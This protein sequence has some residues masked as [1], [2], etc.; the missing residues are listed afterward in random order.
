MLSRSLFQAL[1][2]VLFTPVFCSELQV[3]PVVAQE[4][5][6][7]AL[8]VKVD[9]IVITFH[10]ADSHGLPVN[11][12]RADELTVFDDD[13]PAGKILSLDLLKDAPI[14]AGI[15]MDTSASMRRD[16]AGN[17]AVSYEYA[18]ALLRSGTDQAFVMGFG[19][20]ARVD[21]SWTNSPAAL[22][23]GIQRIATGSE[24]RLAGTA[25]FDNIA[26]ACRTQFA[27][28][29]HA[30]SGNFILL[31]T[32]GEDNAGFQSIKDAVDACQHANTAIYAF[33]SD[34]GA[35]STGPATLAQLTHET[36]GR[37][38]RSSESPT[39][40]SED[41]RVIEAEMRNQYRLVYR[42]RTLKHDGAFHHIALL[43][44]GRVA[45]VDVRSGYYAPTH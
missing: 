3:P 13:K 26:H 28:I 38:F 35:A 43:P 23:Q 20:L 42:P 44:P 21:P 6:T 14:H 30:T 15:L 7:F 18:K 39:E 2:I 1:S 24:S 8:R 25:L 45:T 41:L 27:P 31:F 5:P 32:D 33:R 10:A 11:D 29:D 17:R 12:L 9:E 16:L 40:I 34:S 22:I 37:V 36:G 4:T 19:R